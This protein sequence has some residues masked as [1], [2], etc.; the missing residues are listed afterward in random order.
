MT[1]RVST[2]ENALH[3]GEPH[4]VIE[5][6][7]FTRR[8]DLDAYPPRAVLLVNGEPSDT[9]CIEFALFEFGFGPVTYV[10]GTRD[11][12]IHY[13]MVFH[14]EGF[15]GNLRECRHMWWGE[16]GYTFYLPLE[17]TAAALTALKEWFD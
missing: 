17:A 9:G 10:D 7:T 8:I 3:E 5:E 2:N 15:S 16:G 14:G 11:E 1:W 6:Q 12:T 13:Q 4:Y